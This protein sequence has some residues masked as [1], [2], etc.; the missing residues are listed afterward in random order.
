[1]QS[2]AVYP[3]SEDKPQLPPFEI[4]GKPDTQQIPP[5]AMEITSVS[6]PRRP[7]SDVDEGSCT[8]TAVTTPETLPKE[9]AGEMGSPNTLDLDEPL[10]SPC[11]HHG[12]VDKHNSVNESP[13]SIIANQDAQP[14]QIITLYETIESQ[15]ESLEQENQF[16]K[17]KLAFTERYPEVAKK[18]REAGQL[19]N[20]VAELKGENAM[21]IVGAV[22]PLIENVL[23]PDETVEASVPE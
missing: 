18:A 11:K 7:S 4:Q 10:A 20:T 2:I 1:M 13:K 5:S 16:L 8:S 22:A 23:T 15:K 3:S 6:M 14:K 21:V 19:R 17:D 12:K 9:I